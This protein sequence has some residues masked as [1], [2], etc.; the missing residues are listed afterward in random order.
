M[1]EPSIEEIAK[2]VAD[3]DAPPPSATEA[4]QEPEPEAEAGEAESEP[5]PPKRSK[6][7]APRKKASKKA[8]RSKA[9]ADEPERPPTPVADAGIPD[10]PD[11]Q[12]PFPAQREADPDPPPAADPVQGGSHHLTQ[13]GD[14]AEAPPG[15]NGQSGPPLRVVPPDDDPPPPP[16]P[17]VAVYTAQDEV[18]P[19]ETDPYKRDGVTYEAVEPAEG[20]QFPDQSGGRRA[21]S[22]LTDICREYRVGH[23]DTD[24][25][26]RVERKKPATWQGVSCAGYVGKIVSPLTEAD[27]KDLV[28]GGT[29]ELVV[30]GP[31]PRG[32]KSPF[33]GSAEIKALTKPI[34]VH[35]PGRPKFVDLDQYFES[36]VVHDRSESMH[37]GWD[38][39]ERRRSTMIGRG[40]ATSADAA[41]HRDSLAFAQKELADQRREIRELRTAPSPDGGATPAV[42]EAVRDSARVGVDAVRETAETTKAML[43]RQ[44]NE[45][46]RQLEELR[47]EVKDMRD[48][49]RHQPPGDQHAWGAFAELSKAAFSRPNGEA[50]SSELSRVHEAHQREMERLHQ[51]HTREI[52]AMR[53]RYDEVSKS[54][55]EEVERLRAQTTERDKEM[56]DEFERRERS[57]KEEFER[58]EKHM[59]ER[60]R[61]RL[62]QMRVDHQRELDAIKRQEELL[63]ETN[64]VSLETR[65]SAAEERARQAAEE[66]ERARAE[67]E[68]KED[69]FGQMEKFQ[70]QAEVMGYSK[71]ND[72]NPPKDWKERI[73]ASIGNALENAPT[74]FESAT[75][76]FQARS[77][78]I[79]TS[80][81]A[82]RA[83][84][85]Q[86][87]PLPPRQQP[88]PQVRSGQAAPK[89]RFW[90]SEEG[91]PIQD[92]ARPPEAEVRPDQQP[93]P[94][95][96]DAAAA[97]QAD[98]Q[99]PAGAPPPGAQPPP[100]PE[101]QAPPP[102]AGP[103]QQAAPPQNAPLPVSPEQVQQLRLMLEAN[104]QQGV[105]VEEFAQGLVGQIGPEQLRLVVNGMTADGILEVLSED[106]Q[107]VDSPLLSRD[108]RAWF[109]QVWSRSAQL[110]AQ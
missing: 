102:G 17:D 23:S 38:P 87:R 19:D 61:E 34:V 40:E 4:V 2:S 30:Y 96:G 43:E 86:A 71:G 62:E 79:Q 81:H 5:P 12:A 104:F 66:T 28:G 15:G 6:K 44:I 32:K 63:R 24:C 58:R 105:S 103:P 91:V 20:F 60:N 53:T 9:S 107:G 7:A 57:L 80:V 70:A 73:A 1:N 41:I 85:Q 35:H 56:R 37:G 3:E 110:V 18:P 67:A 99:Q 14:E 77:E 106:P 84:Q 97:Q 29:Y 31:D 26:V 92:T 100:Q 36:D 33:S 76:T 74:I 68:T 16:P 25:Y 8:R 50:S 95:G 47:R 13:G 54:R 82:M 78:A 88:P 39:M 89:R 98:P 55:S 46:E 83:A 90:S 45:K 52:E 49:V 69:F 108:G 51:A 94:V 109:R 10:E 64:K 65:I 27:F 21:P 11:P 75:K 22:N 93:P 101:P 59:E 42:V 48:E 72:E